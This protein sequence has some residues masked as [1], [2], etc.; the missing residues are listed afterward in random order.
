MKPL[1]AK[2]QS[3]S[4][5][6][7]LKICLQVVD[8]GHSLTQQLEQRLPELQDERDR[9]F[10]SELSYGL[11]RYFYILQAQLKQRL[12]KPLKAKDRDIEIVLLMGLYQLRFMRVDD[13]A[14]VNES[15]KLLKSIHKHWAKGLV[16]A[17]LRAYIRDDLTSPAKDVFGLSVQDHRQAYPPW[18]G[19]KIEHD[20][21]AEVKQILT[22]GNLQAPM[23]LRVNAAQIEPRE[24]LRQLQ[25]KG[26]QAHEHEAVYGAIVLHKP[27]SVNRLPGFD[28][29][30]V[31]VQDAAA[32]LA[33]GLLQ[34]EPDMTVLDACAAPGG[35]T[36]H[37]LQASKNLQMTAIDKDDSRLNRVNENLRRAG[38]QATCLVADAS[39]PS[40]WFNGLPFDRILLD[41]PCSASGII[42]RHPDIR[43]LR[44]ETDIVD[45]VSQQQGLLSALW[46]LLKPGGRMLY[47]TCSIFKDEN[48][49]Q[50]LQFMESQASCI[51]V[52][53]KSVQWGQKR[54]VGRQILPGFNDMDGFY[55]ACLEKI[56]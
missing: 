23:V 6:I 43:L 30:W 16:N 36:L 3:N 8:K 10:C 15:V 51:E 49:N 28:R 48:E 13:H 47:S 55:Y 21:P 19:A 33:A 52:E 17:I 29:G 35:K 37:I 9:A 22:A 14:A 24:Y 40:T 7:A 32:Q 25:E 11:C 38:L 5:Q 2:R 46:P 1:P 56:A 34:S 50:V 45:L 4:R 44:R 27:L 12:K 39:A 54:P 26:I 31:S 53:I 42:R 18:M 41:A 20:W